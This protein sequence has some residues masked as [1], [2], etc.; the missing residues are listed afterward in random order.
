MAGRLE[1]GPRINDEDLEA[2][3]INAELESRLN[4]RKWSTH[5]NY[6]GPSRFRIYISQCH[7]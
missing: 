7:A 2:A 6:D 1:T 3:V 4:R 5:P